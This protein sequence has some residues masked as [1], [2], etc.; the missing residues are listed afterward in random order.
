VLEN[1]RKRRHHITYV[2]KK[3]KLIPVKD[4]KDSDVKTTMQLEHLAYLGY[5]FGEWEWHE[6]WN[7]KKYKDQKIELFQE[8]IKVTKIRK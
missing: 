6:Q 7:P 2:V 4:W 5:Y 8:Y 3:K 1:M